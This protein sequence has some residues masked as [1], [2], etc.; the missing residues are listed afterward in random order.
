MKFKEINQFLGFGTTSQPSAF[1][2]TAPTTSAFGQPTQQSA[3][4]STPTTGNFI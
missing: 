2:Q 1:G 3:F 4:G